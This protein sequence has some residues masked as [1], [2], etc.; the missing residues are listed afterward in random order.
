MD[1]TEIKSSHLIGLPVRLRHGYRRRPAR[2]PFLCR[3]EELAPATPGP[4]TPA[5]PPGGGWRGE[6]RE[7]RRGGGEEP[8]AE[9]WRFGGRRGGEAA[10]A[11][12]R[13]RCAMAGWEVRADWKFA[14]SA[15]RGVQCGRGEEKEGNRNAR[16]VHGLHVCRYGCTLF[17]T[18]TT[19]LANSLERWRKS[20]LR[21]HAT[22]VPEYLLHRLPTLYVLH[23][24]YH[25]CIFQSWSTAHHRWPRLMY[26]VV[27]IWHIW[28]YQL[29]ESVF[30]Y[31][32]F[33]RDTI[34]QVGTQTVHREWYSS[35]RSLDHLNTR[36]HSPA[37]SFK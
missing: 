5:Q 6:L 10:A 22:I 36:L 37:Y 27:E 34:D 1:T 21:T 3:R 32:D 25:Y 28:L 35:F 2:P 24:C 11:A 26:F 16:G 14:V 4:P 23:S 20:A 31:N 17:I 7:T 15:A 13:E 19:C 33:T 9:P 29:C 30:A 18:P 8:E 12:A